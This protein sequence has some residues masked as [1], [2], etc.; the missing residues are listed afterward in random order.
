MTFTIFN[1]AKAFQN[2]NHNELQLIR[3]IMNESTRD[4]YIWATQVGR[5]TKREFQQLIFFQ[6]IP[7]CKEKIQFARRFLSNFYEINVS[8]FKPGEASQNVGPKM[9]RSFYP[10]SR[11]EEAFRMGVENE[12]TDE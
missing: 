3:G 9:S 4:E 2:Q 10:A 12:Y 8:H 5:T 6:A 11:D 1:G 7:K